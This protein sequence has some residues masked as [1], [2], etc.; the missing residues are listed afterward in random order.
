MSIE[1]S[2][3]RLLGTGAIASA[4]V[5]VGQALPLGAARAAEK[6]GCTAPP[7]SI[8]PPS[9]QRYDD[10]VTSW[11]GRFTGHP[12]YVSV[13]NS[14][15]EVEAALAKA[16]AQGKRVAVRSG[17]HCFEGFVTDPAVRVEIDMSQMNSITYDPAFQAF[18]I[19]PGA[20]LGEV[21]QTLFVG[22]SV[23]L[24]GGICP[25]VGAGGHFCGGGY[26]PLAR[27]EGIVPDHLYAVEVV[28]VDSTGTPRTVVATRNAN[29]SNRDLWWAHTG[30]GGGNFGIVTKYW[31]RSHGAAGPNPDALLPKPLRKTRITNYAIAWSDLTEA[32]FAT[33]LKGYMAWHESHSA[34]GSKYARLCADLTCLHVN[35]SPAVVIQVIS[36]PTEPDNDSLLSEFQNAVVNPVGVTPAVTDATFP[37]LESTS[38]IAPADTGTIVGVRNKGKSSYIRKL[39]D[40]NQISVTYHYLTN[41]SLTSPLAGV[42]FGSY[43]GAVNAV[44]PTATAVPQ[45][46]SVL[47]ALHTVYWTDPTQDDQYLSWVRHFY[48][49][50]HAS[51]GGV[52]GLDGITDGCYINY[53]DV[54][55][56]NPAWNTSGLSWSQLYYK[57]GYARLQS[58]KAR[59]DPR[60]IFHHAL[61]VQLPGE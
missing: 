30:G 1:I 38:V 47:K 42:L 3:R 48:R 46:D 49:D 58:V 7:A 34:P 51:T 20:T 14:T 33:F 57:E 45:R 10:L 23:T 16:V 40:D 36:D 11:N 35:T 60:N 28:T 53:A 19:E 2:R 41:T 32:K 22:W 15:S 56:A 21:Y 24:P 26:G 43:G 29:D 13:V 17:G 8:V 44:A 5:A 12:D 9:D 27:R 37:W 61:S 18:A 55:I 31:M 6:A 52:P 50:V 59:W 39:Y 54:D 25:T 4:G